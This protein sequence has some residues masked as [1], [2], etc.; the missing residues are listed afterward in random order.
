MVE[1]KE[2]TEEN[3]EAVLKLKISN[4]QDQKR[5]VAPNVRSLADAYLYRNAGDVFPYAVEA[6][7]KVVGFILLDEDVEEK[8]YMIWRMMV[9]E[10]FQGRGYGKAIVKKVIEAFESDERFDV[11][12]ADYVVGNESMK[13]L[14]ESLGFKE[15]KFDESINEYMMEYREGNL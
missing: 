4:A 11:L 9:G 12:I 6:Q 8:E 1:F 15:K 14:L 2:I 3:F 5:F 10:E 7:E 13:K